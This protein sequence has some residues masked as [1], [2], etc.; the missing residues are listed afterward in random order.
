MGHHKAVE[1]DRFCGLP[2]SLIKEM[3]FMSM[4]EVSNIIYSYKL[5]LISFEEA[6]DYLRKIWKKTKT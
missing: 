1:E 6:G 2:V 3:D 4:V 5:G